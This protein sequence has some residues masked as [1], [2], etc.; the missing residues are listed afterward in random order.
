MGVFSVTCFSSVWAYIWMFIVLRDQNVSMVEAWLTLFFF[1]LLIGTAWAADKYKEN[2]VAQEKANTGISEDNKPVIEYSAVDIYRELINEKNGMA[3]KNTEEENKR[4]KMKAFLKDSMNTD[5]IDRVNIDELKKAVE[6][7]P[8]LGR[9]KYR[10]QV[11]LGARRPVVHKG[12]IIKQEHTHAEHIDAK[13]LNPDFGFKCLHYS[14]SEASGSLR[15]Y[16]NNKKGTACK[17]RVLTIDQEAIA[18][19]DYEKVDKILEFK[20]GEKTQHIDVIINDDDNWEPD[21]DFF[22]QL[23]D[24]TTGADLPGVDSRTR[25]TIIDDDKPGQIGFEEQKAIKALATEAAC[26]VII[27]RKNGS[28][29]KVTV[30]YETVQLDQSEHT[31]SPNIDYISTKGTLLFE[32]GETTKTITIEI[33]VREDVDMRDESFGLQ[34]SNITPAGAKLSKKSFQIVNIVTD[35]ESKKKHEALQQL[36]AKIEDEEEQSWA[37]Q[38]ITACMLHPT[39]NEDGEITDITATEGFLHFSCIGWKLLF[40]IIPPPHYNGGMPCFLMSLVFIGIVTYVVG[41]FANLF[42]CVLVVKP[43]ITA[44]TFV[45]LGTSLPDTFAS[46]AAAVQDKYADSAIGNVTGSNSVNVFLGLGLP[47]VI[48]VLW[49]S[50]VSAEVKGYTSDG[51]YV[52]AGSLGFSVIVFCVCAITAIIFLLFRRK[53]VGGELGGSQ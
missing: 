43:S 33:L 35:V 48:A 39:K 23:M 21:E 45:A 3:P 25:V 46:M 24:A 53:Y 11:G 50:S 6:G 1:F 26:E 52:P 12:E 18:G 5:Q 7:G 37:S 41:E 16:I 15:I 28:D 8:M 27:L 30:D 20:Q 29:G 32:Q 42:G 40:S 38:F 13:L 49:E 14:V 47:W 31:A 9:L 2:Q 19:N 51:Y 22:V 10:K 17:V 44:I 4:H 36:L 34:L